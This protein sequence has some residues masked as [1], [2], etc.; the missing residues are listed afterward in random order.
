MKYTLLELTQN[1]LSAMDSDEVNSIADT[2]EARQVAEVIRTAYFNIVARADPGAHKQL[3]RLDA[4][5]DNL[6]PVLMIVNESYRSIEWIKYNRSTNENPEANYQY[7]S[8]IPNQ[9]FYDMSHALNS[10]DD[11]VVEV[12]LEISGDANNHSIWVRNDKF[13]DY[14]TIL[15]NWEDDENNRNVVIFDSFDFDEEDT[16]QSERVLC[17]GIAYPQFELSD[18]FTPDLDE[19]QF[20]LLLN[21]AKALA[22]F[23]L[24]QQPHEKA[25]QESRRQWRTLQRTKSVVSVPSSFDQFPDFGRRGN[26]NSTGFPRWMRGT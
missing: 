23:E 16:L 18:S 17:G 8:I 10:E 3:F 5:G 4:S 11:N 1:L 22:F 2:T 7:V 24:K 20:P 14:C 12:E 25:E 15:P 26:T 9:Q 13:P 19:Q 21:E 6:L